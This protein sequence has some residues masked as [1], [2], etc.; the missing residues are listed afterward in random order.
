MKPSLKTILIAGLTAGTLDLALAITYFG[1]TAH[2]PFTA[3]PQTVA[4]GILGARAFRLGISAALLGIFLHYFIA[5]TVA[6]FYYAGSLRLK[7][8]NRHPIL[9]G[10]AYGLAVYLV[11][12]FIVVPLSA[13]SHAHPAHA[14][15]LANRSWLIADIASHILFIGITIA[16]IT[17]HYSTQSAP[18]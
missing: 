17:R 2:A 7:F 9:S 15:L 10:A 6:D 14:W 16:L 3:V 12:T 1:I 8:L 13:A 5:L 18:A 4:S 11:M